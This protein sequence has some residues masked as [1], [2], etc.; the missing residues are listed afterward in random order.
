MLTMKYIMGQ[1]DSNN[2]PIDGPRSR[3][4]QKYVTRDTNTRKS[5]DEYFRGS[6]IIYYNYPHTGTIHPGVKR[7]STNVN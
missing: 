3:I 5:C 4:S 6:R 7:K 2:R 1:L